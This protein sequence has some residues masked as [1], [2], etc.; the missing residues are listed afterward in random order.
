[1]ARQ[2]RAERTRNAILD[3]A[4]EVF[5]QRGFSGA[6]LSEILARADLTKGALYFHFSSKEDLAKAIVEE[7]W[8]IDTPHVETTKSPMQGVIDVC[9]AFGMSLCSNIRVR[10]S[11]RLVTE[12]NFEQ[13]N[14]AV[15][16]R[17]NNITYEFLVAAKEAGDLRAELD[18]AAVSM[19]LGG[20]FLGIQ[21][22][23]GVLT[24][25]ADLHERIT[26][27][28]KIALPGLVPARR[29]SRFN[30]SGTVKWDTAA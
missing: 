30:P 21:I 6:S 29:L 23:S 25:R 26:D 22:M 13:P 16:Q 1:M 3:A 4:A 5:E 24:N 7:Q 19:W 27:L 14:P 20:S 2:D 10:A 11:N 8:N 15:Y 17:W 12:S 28:F 9:H 18:P